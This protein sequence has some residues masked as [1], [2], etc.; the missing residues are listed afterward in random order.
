MSSWFTVPLQAWPFL[1]AAA[2]L[3]AVE[4]IES[5]QTPGPL[6]ALLLLSPQLVFA[7]TVAGGELTH[8]DTEEVFVL[9]MMDPSLFPP[10]FEG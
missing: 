7:G 5:P 2:L 6:G 8:P 9:F 10:E 4:L 3:T 1:V